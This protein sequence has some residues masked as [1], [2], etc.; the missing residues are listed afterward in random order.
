[1]SCLNRK[2][3]YFISVYLLM[4]KYANDWH[5]KVFVVLYSYNYVYLRIM[6]Y[7]L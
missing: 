1:M 3:D 2:M 4:C 6:N 5:A 7:E